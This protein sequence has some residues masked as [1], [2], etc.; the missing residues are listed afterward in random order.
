MCF[1]LI[2]KML[3]WL[4]GS[5]FSFLKVQAKYKTNTMCK[6]SKCPT[7]ISTFEHI[8]N[9][10]FFWSTKPEEIL[11]KSRIKFFDQNV[12]IVTPWYYHITYMLSLYQE[13]WWKVSS[14]LNFE[15]SMW[16]WMSKG[17]I[18]IFNQKVYFCKN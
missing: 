9:I 6:M 3:F 18:F 2:S 7:W 10:S 5:H 16:L 12:L 11:N 13:K 8:P 1:Y 14:V 4:E 17:I 15:V